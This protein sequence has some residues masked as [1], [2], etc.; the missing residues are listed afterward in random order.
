MLH[1]IP[2]LSHFID[3][4]YERLAIKTNEQLRVMLN[5]TTEQW[6]TGPAGSGK[7]WLLM[8]KVK[9]LAQKIRLHESGERILVVCFNRP[10]SKM[11]SR[12]FQNHLKSLLPRDNL[13]Q[14]ADVKTFDCLLHEITGGKYGQTDAEKKEVVEQAVKLLDQPAHGVQRYDHIFVDECQDLLGD[15][16]PSLFDKLCKDDGD[17]YDGCEPKHKWFFYDP[18]QHL[19][20]SEKRCKQHMRFLKKSTK[21]SKVLRNTGNV[22]D[23]SKK[24]FQSRLKSGDPIE[25]GHQEC[26]LPIKW[27]R[28]LRNREIAKRDGAE[29]IISHV[30][31]LEKNKVQKKDICVLVE[32]V[33]ARQRL[34]CELKNL[35]VVCQNAERLHEANDDKVV[36]E[37]IWRFKGLEAKVVILY[38][39]RY[40]FDKDGTENNVRELLY[41][42]VSRCFCYLIIVTTEEG[43]KAMASTQGVLTRKRQH[44]QSSLPERPI[45]VEGSDILEPGDNFI[46]DSSRKKCFD[47]LV[48]PVK[49]NVVCI[50]GCSASELFE[51]TAK[52]IVQ[53]IEYGV[54]CIFRNDSNSANYSRK[55]RALI[56][57]ITKCNEEQKVHEEVKEAYK[58][59]IQRR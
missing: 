46:N 31:E 21:L 40:D 9:S 16:W 37:S 49:Q 50:K 6:I 44:Q 1:S 15:R 58:N 41:T 27:D 2:P 57:E 14:V 29:F 12:A 42:A 8:E 39:P 17:T 38:N 59:K 4:S 56:R 36:V 20:L 32:N 30:K 19:R 24:Y 55:F 48:N 34:T 13:S 45:E 26:G 52:G 10:L 51:S 28:S 7:T 43:Y 54:Y 5:S 11:L 35:G 18:N 25:L 23:Q 47:L 3:T 33:E 53:V 22:F